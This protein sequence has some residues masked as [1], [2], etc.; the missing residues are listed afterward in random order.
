MHEAA[1]ILYALKYRKSQRS[2][3]G[4]QGVS[5]WE[6]E[7]GSIGSLRIKDFLFTLLRIFVRSKLALFSASGAAP[8]EVRGWPL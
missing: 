1:V 2:E 3:G 7:R 5:P 4:V 6:K 8:S